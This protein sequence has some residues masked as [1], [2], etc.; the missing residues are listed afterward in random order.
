MLEAVL[1]F[2]DDD[3]DRP[4]YADPD[5]QEVDP[6][7]W[8]QLCEAVN[9]ALEGDGDASGSRIAD[10]HVFAWRVL[11]KYGVSFVAVTG[12]RVKRRRVEGYLKKLSGRYLDEVTDTR[13]PEREGVA[14]VVIDV[15][16][17]WDDDDV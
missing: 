1:I 10:G 6:D 2:V 7:L 11:L 13:S 15:V 3:F 14:D 9:D 12:E 16:P 4:V 17:D 5:P 8:H